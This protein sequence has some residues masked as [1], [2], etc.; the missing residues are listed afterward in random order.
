V[1][2]NFSL[3]QYQSNSNQLHNI[4]QNAEDYS[5]PGIT[6]NQNITAKKRQVSFLSADVQKYCYYLLNI[7]S[8]NR[9]MPF[10]NFIR[11]SRR[12]LHFLQNNGTLIAIEVAEL[13]RM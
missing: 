1:Y 7:N 3:S 9:L 10:F 13:T 4:S 12:A 2:R 6:A 8:F 5:F 11:L